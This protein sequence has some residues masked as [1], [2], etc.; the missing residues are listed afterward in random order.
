M[1]KP[2]TQFEWF[3][4]LKPEEQSYWAERVHAVGIAKIIIRLRKKGSQEEKR[5]VEKLKE[6]CINQ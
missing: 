4:G 6:H 1:N 3:Q 5:Y 2:K